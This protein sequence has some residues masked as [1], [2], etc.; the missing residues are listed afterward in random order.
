MF[1]LSCGRA[2]LVKWEE[3]SSLILKGMREM[4]EANWTMLSNR[5]TEAL[6]SS[7]C[8]PKPLILAKQTS[9]DSYV[10]N[11]EPYA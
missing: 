7:G 10:S 9:K 4:S 5:S 1:V 2:L 3:S 6:C 8:W 11:D